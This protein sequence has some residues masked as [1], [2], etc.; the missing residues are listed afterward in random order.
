MALREIVT[1]GSN[2]CLRKKARKIENINQRILTLLDDMLE[3][4]YRANGVGIAAPQV[5]ILRRAFVID[6]GDGPIE[7]IN[8]EI[9]EHKGEQIDKEG[10]LSVPGL[11][12]TVLRPSYVKVKALD[13]E[14]K[15]FEL[16]GVDLMARAICHELDHLNGILFVDRCTA[17]KKTED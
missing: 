12:G 9:I 4:M 11:E 13:R 3:T 1:Y 7:F 2:D 6:V 8:P 5:G 17:V 16:E 10:C 15:E 14:G